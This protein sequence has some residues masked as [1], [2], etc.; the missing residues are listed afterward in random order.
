MVYHTFMQSVYGMG[1]MVVMQA[2][3]FSLICVHG[4][5]ASVDESRATVLQLICNTTYDNTMLATHKE[6]SHFR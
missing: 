6:L 3:V 2:R 5:K 1:L 4:P